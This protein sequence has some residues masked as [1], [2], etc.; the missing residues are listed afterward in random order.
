MGILNKNMQ[1]D[2]A[3]LVK[4]DLF[5]AHL[6][7]AGNHIARK[8]N[9][10]KS[11]VRELLKGQSCK[12]ITNRDHQLTEQSIISYIGKQTNRRKADCTTRAISNCQEKTIFQ[13]QS[14]PQNIR[15]LTKNNL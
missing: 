13:R 15:L 8:Q 12:M 3:I 14:P 4:N 7:F 10:D 6:R 1:I 9:M 2:G 5:S 11:T